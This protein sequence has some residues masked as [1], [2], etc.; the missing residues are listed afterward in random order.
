MIIPQGMSQNYLGESWCR[1][2]E[3]VHLLLEQEKPL[4]GF[5]QISEVQ[6]DC[7]VGKGLSQV[8][9]EAEIIWEILF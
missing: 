1:R 3:T 2:E 6:S 7:W 4:G 8:N 5:E 9:V